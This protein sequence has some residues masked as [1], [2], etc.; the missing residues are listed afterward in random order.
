M[1]R[2]EAERL[3]AEIGGEVEV[4]LRGHAGLLRRLLGNEPNQDHPAWKLAAAETLAE[5]LLERCA[6]LLH[7]EV[8]APTRALLEEAVTEG[9]E[10]LARLAADFDERLR[11]AD[12]PGDRLQALRARRRCLELRAACLDHLANIFD[13]RRSRP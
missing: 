12:A 6:G 11:A 4:R 1:K 9:P 8:S 10:A 2:A 5:G 3:L 13:A 7:P